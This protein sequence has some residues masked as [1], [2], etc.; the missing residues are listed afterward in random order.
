MLPLHVAL[1]STRSTVSA[2]RLSVASAL[3]HAPDAHVNVADLDGSYTPIADETVYTLGDL[4]IRRDELHRSVV[5]LGVLTAARAAHSTLADRLSDG[6]TVLALTAGVVLLGAP[7][8]LVAGARREGIC[9]VPRSTGALPRD[10][11]WPG[12][13]ALA[14]KGAHAVEM[15]A[16]QG[17]Q[18]KLITAWRDTWAV[19]GDRWLDVALSRVPHSTLRAPTAL[20]SPWNLLADQHISATGPSE[21]LLADIRLD[22][23][24][25]AALDLSRLD[26]SRPWELAPQDNMEHRARLSEHPALTWA[27]EDAARWIDHDVMDRGQDLSG[28]DLTATSLGFPIDPLIRSLVRGSCTE[29]IASPDTCAPD[30]IDPAAAP[31]FAAWLADPSGDEVL[32]RYLL[33]LHRSRPDLR[34]AFPGVPGE[35]TSAFLAWAKEH[36]RHEPAYPPGLVDL[37]LRRAGRPAP[38][39]SA[40]VRPNGV[41]V[42][43]YLR[44]ELGIG[45][46]A[47]LMV[48]ALT[49]AHVPH[50][51]V[52]ADRHLASRQSAVTPLRHDGSAFDT[53]LI[54]VNADMTAEVARTVPALLAH[55]YRIGMWYWEVENFPKEQRGA[56]ADV[57]EVWVATDFVRAAIEPHSPVPVRTLTPPL[58]QPRDVVAINRDRLGL[59]DYPFLL[60]SFDYLS[61]AERKNPLGLVDAFVRAFTPD[62]RVVLVVKSINSNLRPGDAERLRCRAA[63]EPHVVLIEDYLD[64]DDRDGLLAACHAYVSL[65]RAE[66]LGL[67][68]A[69]AM[70]LGKPVIATG[71]SGNLQ[72][73]T[74]ENSF[75]VPW[76]PIAIP[77]GAAPYPEGT[78]WADPDLDAAAEMMRLVIDDPDLAARRGARA[79]SD[80]LSHSPELAGRR[81][82]AR[83]AEIQHGSPLG[84]IGA[85]VRGIAR[86][87]RGG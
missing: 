78:V 43:G 48:R 25:V 40:G 30:P 27:C 10:G 6:A 75:L 15:F 64:A 14:Q 7:T 34:T 2:A 26:P 66:G 11:R 51:T 21:I 39:P 54:C 77:A 59:P 61:T 49:A 13:D 28:F 12:E 55:T 47:R 29:L 16:L 46:S 84:S 76:S 83:L 19:P 20:L 86:L 17:A 9:V 79:A 71:Y 73:M 3:R 70:A 18:P 38:V 81:I 50:H 65:H 74:P 41:N 4:G 5:A 57:D 45:E 63:L 80:M 72:F 31:E 33:A 8:A 22:G 67:T 24:A 87:A 37:C 32:G 85:R 36:G 60:F 69:E 56:F 52:S 42:V 62:D 53:S 23:Q 58:P 82:A 35:H 1:V 68:M 44:G